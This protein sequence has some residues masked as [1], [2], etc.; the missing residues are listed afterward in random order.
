M[1]L[2]TLAALV[3]GS[4]AIVFVLAIRRL[5]GDAEDDVAAALA[6]IL[7]SPAGAGRPRP[8]PDE[9]VRWR[10]EL[11]S[12]RVPPAVEVAAPGRGLGTASRREI[13]QVP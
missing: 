12:R 9:V 5:D 13:P 11:V 6:T 10:V 1:D 7:G 3:F 8:E 4:I 2:D